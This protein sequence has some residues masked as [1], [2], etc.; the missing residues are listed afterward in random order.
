MP[1]LAADRAEIGDVL[2]AYAWALDSKSYELLRGVFAA[3]IVA[4]F[5]IGAPWTNV[6]DLVDGMATLHDRLD[7]TQ[8]Q[9]SNFAIQLDGD[10]ASVRSYIH[11]VLTKRTDAGRQRLAM[12]G[13]YED[14]FR[15]LTEGWRIIRRTAKSFWMDGD[16]D[17]LRQAVA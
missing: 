8:H 6:H 3:D 10:T 13:Y 14:E 1:D 16:R 7:G 11:A 9:V 2:V 17:V 12:G 15:R 4:D 5:G